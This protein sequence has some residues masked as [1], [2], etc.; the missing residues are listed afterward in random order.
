MHDLQLLLDCFPLLNLLSP[1]FKPL[2]SICVFV[3]VVWKQVVSDVRPALLAELLVACKHIGW[4][5]V[6]ACWWV[7]V[8]VLEVVQVIAL[9]A[10]LVGKEPSVV[11]L[12]FELLLL[13]HDLAR[14]DR[15]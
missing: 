11:V 14:S 15:R 13:Q 5:I 2:D 10:M 3:S 8:N 7:I 12:D 9:A 1:I 6:C 4:I